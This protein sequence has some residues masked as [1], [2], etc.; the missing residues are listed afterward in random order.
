MMKE[1]QHTTCL[2]LSVSSTHQNQRSQQ[3]RDLKKSSMMKL[4]SK[5]N[6]AKQK[7][8]LVKRDSSKAP[9][10]TLSGPILAKARYDDLKK[11][12]ELRNGNVENS[13]MSFLF[14][15][16]NFKALCESPLVS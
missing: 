10:K 14:W 2:S 6:P 11:L 3:N 15:L 9:K 1:N 4:K 5:K 16:L 8:L 7:L 12:I 13:R